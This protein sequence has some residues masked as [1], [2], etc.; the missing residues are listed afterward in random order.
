MMAV[1][2]G[3][4]S[5]TIELDEALWRAAEKA[6]DIHDPAELVRQLIEREVRRREAE[7]R[8]IAAGG[9]MP[10]LEIPPRNRSST[11]R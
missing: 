2:D 9:T 3:R 11:H 8:L 5:I 7:T 10:D 6:T 4:M 1:Y